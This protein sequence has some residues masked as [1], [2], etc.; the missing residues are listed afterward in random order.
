VDALGLLF[1]NRSF[2]N[3]GASAR[4]CRKFAAC[5]VAGPHSVRVP[6]FVA[7]YS[8]SNNRN[9]N[10]VYGVSGIGERLSFAFR[11]G[12]PHLQPQGTSRLDMDVE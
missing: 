3:F 4:G 2:R 1:V 9:T 5:P 10:L 12:G 8:R 7:D 11:V 6:G